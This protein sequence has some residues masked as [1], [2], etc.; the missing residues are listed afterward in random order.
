MHHI[1]YGLSVLAP[2]LFNDVPDGEVADLATL[3]G[4]LAKRGR[5][6]AYEVRERFYEIGSFE[7]LEATRAFLASRGPDGTRSTAPDSW[8]P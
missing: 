6:A 7:G 3:Y 4:L 1:D 8:L 2:S 5:L